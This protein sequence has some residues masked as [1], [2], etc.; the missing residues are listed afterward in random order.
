MEGRGE[1]SW[2]QRAFKATVGRWRPLLWKRTRTAKGGENGGGEE[3]W[4]EERGGEGL[5][6]NGNNNRREVV[7]CVCLPWKASAYR[8]RLREAL[9]I[10]RSAAVGGGS[11]RSV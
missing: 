7:D 3:G 2:F 8:T 6:P 10:T 4:E 9:G 1:R 11:A 5:A